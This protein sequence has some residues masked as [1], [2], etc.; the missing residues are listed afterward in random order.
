VPSFIDASRLTKILLTSNATG[1]TSVATPGN[2]NVNELL[3]MLH[4]S[5][6][7]AGTKSHQCESFIGFTV[8]LF[9]GGKA[10]L[11]VSISRSPQTSSILLM[12]STDDTRSGCYSLKHSIVAADLQGFINKYPEPKK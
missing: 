4:L 6:V 1:R 3:N 11:K 5:D 7:S 12:D 9:E 2:D 8:A 10:V